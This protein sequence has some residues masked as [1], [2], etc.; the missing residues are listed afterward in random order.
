M[1]ISMNALSMYSGD[2]IYAIDV[3]VVSKVVRNMD[4]TVVPASQETVIG[5]ASLKG[6]II[7]L[8]SLSMLLG[9]DRSEAETHA[10]V[11]KPLADGY[12]QMGLMVDNPG[13]LITVEDDS[14]ISSHLTSDDKIAS[15]I[16]GLVESEGKLYRIIDVNFIMGRF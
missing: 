15:I 6:G 10:I 5:I 16:S 2:E 1:I 11:L 9:Y 7:T 12:G 8:L 3:S 14:T 4:W 13:D